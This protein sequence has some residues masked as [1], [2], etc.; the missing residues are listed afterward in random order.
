VQRA[1]KKIVELRVQGPDDTMRSRGSSHAWVQATD[2]TGR[3]VTG[4]LT[5]PEA[6]T[7]TADAAIRAVRAVLEGACRPGA[8]TPSQAFGA[9]FVKEL[10]GV[11][12][13]A[14]ERG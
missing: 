10:D 13:H 11:T 2:A 3:R 8:W 1:L 4:T 12:V 5:G 7:L 9:E 14:I 6:Y